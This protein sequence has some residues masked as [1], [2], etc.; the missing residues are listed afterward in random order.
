M[1]LCVL[2]KKDRNAPFR[3]SVSESISIHLSPRFRWLSLFSSDGGKIP[4][5]ESRRNRPLSQKA[6]KIRG[7]QPTKKLFFLT[8][9]IVLPSQTKQVGTQKVRPYILTLFCITAWIE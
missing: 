6:A 7:K 1:K 8:F 4:T 9:P 3:D 5:G 2:N